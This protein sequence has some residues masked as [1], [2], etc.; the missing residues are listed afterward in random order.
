[1]EVKRLIEEERFQ[2]LDNQ[3][4]QI[5]RHLE[6]QNRVNKTKFQISF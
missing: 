4:K 2:K 1:M 6:N 3:I 5:E